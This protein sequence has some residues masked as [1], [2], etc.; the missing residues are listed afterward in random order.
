M[1][2]LKDIIN[3]RVN[4]EEE[5][6]KVISRENSFKELLELVIDNEKIYTVKYRN[7]IISGYVKNT[8]HTK[9]Y[10]LKI[11]NK[12]TSL[13]KQFSFNQEVQLAEGANFV[14]VV[15]Y[16]NDTEKIK[17]TIVIYRKTKDFQ[18][19]EVVLWVEQFP[20]AKVFET[21]EDIEKMMLTAKKAGVTAY[22]LDIK[23]PEGF[24]SYKKNELS[25]SP[26]I[27]EIKHPKKSGA[28]RDFDLLE[29]FIAIA[30]KLEMKVFASINVFVEGNIILEESAF[31]KEHSDWE[32][33]IQ[34][35]E[36]KGALLPISK[37]SFDKKILSFVNP[38]N[39]EVQELQLNR[40]EEVLKNYDVD[41]VN[42]DRCRYDNMYADFSEVTREKFEAF[43]NSRNMKLQNWPDDVYKI[44][45]DGSLVKGS[46]YNYWWQ[47]RSSLIKNFAEKVRR[48]VDKYTELKERKILLSAYV[49]SW[50]EYL[51][52]NGINW[53]SPNFKYDSRLAFPEDSLYTEKY[54]ETGYTDLLDFIM[55]GTYYE[56]A[57]EINKY[58]TL[59]NII[60]NGELPIYAGMALTDIPDAEVQREVFQAALN[61]SNGLMLFDLCYT[62]W[63]VQ[64][65][66][67]KNYN[68][69][70]RKMGEGK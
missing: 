36:D 9:N 1:K 32:E 67:I 23:G 39:D 64:E 21:V 50:Y 11:N 53:A 12:E 43:L 62:D 40:F 24:V 42:L 3:G 66:A 19:K 29:E 16:E 54:A 8:K 37:S 27:S 63:P 35:P 61:N 22:G 49:G 51:Y 60:T 6:D 45:A 69:S 47:F 31:L 56:T 68:N 59:G 46:L 58:I 52:Q 65:A 57:K 48:L 18:D 26:Y 20:N 5:T 4:C 25:S 15:L 17:E 30:H 34:R 28:S 2:E 7:A 33:I 55:I 13:N 14:D 70:K 41:G 38:A 44:E 10:K